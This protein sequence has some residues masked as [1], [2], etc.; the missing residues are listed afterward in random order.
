LEGKQQLI[1][2]DGAGGRVRDA[3][4]RSASWIANRAI[5]SED[6]RENFAEKMRR[7]QELGWNRLLV[8]LRA[9]TENLGEEPAED[10]RRDR[11]R[12]ARRSL[13]DRVPDVQA[14]EDPK[15][16]VHVAGVALVATEG[17]NQFRG[18]PVPRAAAF[19]EVVAD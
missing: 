11:D 17:P 3:N 18:R 1:M 12:D 7:T 19:R 13:L 9:T 14:A 4:T 6:A 2:E 5:A 15:Q 10:P 8:R 16:I